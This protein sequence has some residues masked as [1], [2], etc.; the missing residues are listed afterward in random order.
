MIYKK[1][2]APITAVM[3]PIGISDAR[4]DLEMSSETSKKAAPDRA[5]AGMRWVQLLPKTFLQ[6][7]GIINPTQPIMPPAEMLAAVSKVAQTM[8]MNLKRLV[9]I[10]M[11]CASSSLSDRR[12]ILYRKKKSGTAPTSIGINAAST[13]L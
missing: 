1:T 11:L 2:G 5:E 6:I 13:F 12:L 3:I 8:T 10:P 7:L 4:T 9:L